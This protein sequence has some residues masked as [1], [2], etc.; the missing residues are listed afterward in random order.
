ML[1]RRTFSIPRLFV[2]CIAIC[3]LISCTLLAFISS[4]G[5]P[6]LN[7]G[8]LLK[9]YPN[10]LDDELARIRSQPDGLLHRTRASNLPFDGHMIPTDSLLALATDRL[11]TEQLSL[12]E[13]LQLRSLIASLDERDS[14]VIDEA[15]Y[16]K[17]KSLLS[18]LNDEFPHTAEPVS[19][20]QLCLVL[21]ELL[22]FEHALLDHPPV[23]NRFFQ[24]AAYLAAKLGFRS[25]TAVYEAL[26][27][28][29]T[30]LWISNIH[31]LD[32]PE[33]WWDRSTGASRTNQRLANTNT[34]VSETLRPMR[35][36]LV[37]GG[38]H[39]ELPC[40]ATVGVQVH[41][42][43]QDWTKA[44]LD[45]PLSNTN[46]EELLLDSLETTWLRTMFK[47]CSSV[48]STLPTIVPLSSALMFREPNMDQWY[49]Q[50]V[51]HSFTPVYPLRKATLSK[52]TTRLV[53][54]HQVALVLETEGYAQVSVAAERLQVDV[55]LASLSTEVDA[56]AASTLYHATQDVLLISPVDDW[57]GA[58]VNVE[59]RRTSEGSK[60]RR[61]LGSIPP[62]EGHPSILNR[63]SYVTLGSGR[64]VEIALEEPILV[65]EGTESAP[66][67]YSY[68]R[69]YFR[70]IQ[71]RA[72][73][74]LHIETVSVDDLGQVSRVTRYAEVHDIHVIAVAISTVPEYFAI[75]EYLDRS[76]RHRC[77]LLHSSAFRPNIRLIEDYP[78]QATFA[79]PNV[80]LR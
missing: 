57:I 33:R 27:M 9:F 38:S 70:R 54:H 68:L 74:L 66:S 79:D 61:V 50:A 52:P 51:D 35:S 8:L 42:I 5:D 32:T 14:G 36:R 72:K 40:N 44:R 22:A 80:L 65:Q 2:V 63:D 11:A 56:R 19:R 34:D 53:P 3:A 55:V 28:G 48:G 78:S 20:T 75:R 15:Y 25:K 64:S 1:A 73:V 46:W 37:L 58:L 26:S 60:A 47:L 18:S 4:P 59:E 24:N 17:Y 43:L 31:R 21:Y 77:V 10:A 12:F 41:R 71:E 67:V 62:V 76:L 7:R 16:L 49:T 13:Q 30:P 29:R 45:Y 23:P 6:W 69:E 39:I